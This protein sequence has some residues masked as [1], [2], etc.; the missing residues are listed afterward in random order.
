VL[1]S[2]GDDGRLRSVLV[3]SVAARWLEPRGGRRRLGAGMDFAAPWWP[4]RRGKGVLL[5]VVVPT[6][7]MLL[8]WQ[9]QWPPLQPAPGFDE[10]WTAGPAMA[11]HGGWCSA[12]RWCSR[13][14]R[15]GSCRWGR[16]GSSMDVHRTGGRPKRL[17]FAVGLVR[18]YTRRPPARRELVGCCLRARSEL[19]RGAPVRAVDGKERFC[20]GDRGGGDWCVLASGVGSVP[21]PSAGSWWSRQARGSSWSH[22]RPALRDRSAPTWSCAVIQHSRAS[23]RTD[24]QSRSSIGPA[25]GRLRTPVAPGPVQ[26]VVPT[27]GDRGG[28][29]LLVVP[30]GHATHCPD[31]ERPGVHSQRPSGD[32]RPKRSGSSEL[33]N[34]V[35][36]ANNSSTNAR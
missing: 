6:V 12:S 1:P 9:W 29:I 10:I 22:Q 5:W 26:V 19:W 32:G 13:M 14:G 30:A 20:V 33:S 28:W 7:I 4:A 15:L 24:R 2:R 36:T 25:S 31:R 35:K 3:P 27:G 17:M 21:G 11:A 8:G 34:G 16:C 18:P 23:P